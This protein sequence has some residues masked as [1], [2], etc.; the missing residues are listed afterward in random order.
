MYRNSSVRLEVVLANEDVLSPGIYPVSIKV[1]GPNMQMVMKRHV[2]ITIPA[3]DVETT[4]SFAIPVFKEDVVIDGPEGQYRFTVTFDSGA[5]ASGGDREFYVYDRTLM[6]K[7]DE[8]VLCGEDSEL[9]AWLKANGIKTRLFD[10]SENGL[11]VILV[12]GKSTLPGGEAAFGELVRR[13]AQGS[14]IIFLSPEVFR[15]DENALGM[16]PLRNKGSL[17]SIRQSLYVRDHW[18][19]DHMIFDGLS[20]GGMLDWV[21]FAEIIP[22]VGFSGWQNYLNIKSDSKYLRQNFPDEVIAASSYAAMLTDFSSTLL[23]AKYK[24]GNGSFIINTLRIRENI[25]K[26]PVAERLLRNMLRYASQNVAK[27]LA[28]LPAD[29]DDRLKITNLK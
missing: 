23:L 20:P 4:P 19:K 13:I 2:Q 25:G 21:K 22:D 6:P 10:S 24:L 15:N 9:A 8:V 18:H 26:D 17:T 14:S 3:A 27:K 29:F 16:V 11:Q 28:P 1:F 7:V 12:S 5:A